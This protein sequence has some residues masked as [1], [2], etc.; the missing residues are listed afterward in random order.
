MKVTIPESTN[1]VPFHTLAAGQAFH[2]APPSP[3]RVFLK[4]DKVVTDYCN[5]CTTL[6]S[7]DL[8]ERYPEITYCQ[9]SGPYSDN[10]NPLPTSSTLID[11]L[12]SVYS[13]CCQAT[14][15]YNCVNLAD[16]TLCFAH[17]GE[18]CILLAAEVVIKP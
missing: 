5:I 15:E 4:L 1:T 11:N 12:T 17:D 18:Q 7:G 2:F 9:D 8:A 3:K 16:G 10:T 14:Q 13:D 6:N